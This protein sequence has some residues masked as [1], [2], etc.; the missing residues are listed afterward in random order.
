MPDRVRVGGDYFHGRVPAGAVYVGRPA[1]GLPGSPFHNPFRVGRPAP[2]GTVPG[3][4]GPI[5]VDTTAVDA[6]HAVDLYTFLIL[7]DPDYQARARVALYGRDL[8]CWCRIGQSC[9]ADPLL[10]VVNGA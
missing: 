8:A 10:T 3:P 1:P 5:I 4:A 6:A 9:H 2:L 7:A